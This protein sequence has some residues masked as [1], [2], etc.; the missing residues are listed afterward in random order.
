MTEGIAINNIG[1]FRKFNRSS[2]LPK[3]SK[4]NQ[5]N[6][7]IDYGRF[8]AVIII[9]LFHAKAPL[10]QFGPTAVAFFV[11]AMVFFS[12]RSKAATQPFSQLMETRAR[13]LLVPWLV[14]LAIYAAAKIA[15]NLVSGEDPVAD[16][17]AWLPPTGTTG[18][19][20]FL[21]FA[22]ITSLL[23]AYWTIKLHTIS[24]NRIGWALLGSLTAFFT[25]I[26]I[27]AWTIVGAQWLGFL[28]YIVYLP[29]LFFGILLTLAQT[30]KA[31]IIIVCGA[32]ALGA[33][34][35]SFGGD[36][37]QQIFIGIPLA[38]IA[39]EVRLPETRFARK[40][41]QISMGIYLV[42]LL[43]IAALPRATGIDPSTL[44][45]GVLCCLGAV[46]LALLI[47]ATPLRR[48]T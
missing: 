34:I 3:I 26:S 48:L 38:M 4:S 40:L 7:T 21:P 19:L 25:I 12:M 17:L 31:R 27:T 45:G 5:Y 1:I 18:Q 32:L 36:M 47:D 30:R 42:H 46:G 13:R 33:I 43:V 10:G 41:G 16:L 14:W 20:W 11:V 22:F 15:Q 44:L 28:I 8:V 9:V 35:A 24:E 6:A 39:L 37:T 23:L 29:S 2:D